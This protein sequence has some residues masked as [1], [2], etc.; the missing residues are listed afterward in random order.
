MSKIVLGTAQFGLDYG[1]NN[2]NGK[3]SREDGCVILNQAYE[4]GIDTID[5]ASAYGDSEIT[6]GCFIEEN[7]NRFKVISKLPR[8]K[9]QEVE[10]AG[11]SSLRRMKVDGLYG[12]LIHNFDHYSSEPD[13][14]NGLEKMKAGGKIKKIGFS[15][16]YPRELENILEKDLRIDIIQLPYSVFDQRFLS[17]FPELKKR[18]IEIQTRSVFLQ[19]LLFKKADELSGNFYPIKRKIENIH[20]LA[21]E[22][23]IP[24]V[25]LLLNF[26]LL[27][28]S[29]DRVVVGIDSLQNLKEI[30]TSAKYLDQTQEL[31]GQ[32]NAFK[33]DD[34]NILVPSNWQL[35]AAR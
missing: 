5:T 35:V 21:Q 12:Y 3:I 29:I 1:I 34:E 14:W 27:N 32:L 7:G 19:G 23:A 17:Y 11:L 31:L 22:T 26:T 28:E 2:V 4:L 24:L 33:D 30:M 13:I 8:C 9:P 16:Y 6:I 20:R 25:S 10:G 18:G 15:L